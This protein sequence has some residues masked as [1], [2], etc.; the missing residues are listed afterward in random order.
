M[1]ER[2]EE[3]A[4]PRCRFA[5]GEFWSLDR[6]G[7][8][9]CEWCAVRSEL[10]VAV[11]ALGGT[12]RHGVAI[13]RRRVRLRAA[14]WWSRWRPLRRQARVGARE[15]E[16]VQGARRGWIPQRSG[17]DRLRVP[18]SRWRARRGAAEAEPVRPGFRAVGE[19]S[20]RGGT[21]PDWIVWDEAFGVAVE[22]DELVRWPWSWRLVQSARQAWTRAGWAR[23]RWGHRVRV[24]AARVRRDVPSRRRLRQGRPG[25]P[26]GPASDRARGIAANVPVGG[27]PPEWERVL[28]DVRAP[29]W[30]RLLREVPAPGKSAI[31]TLLADAAGVGAPSLRDRLARAGQPDGAG[32]ASELA[33]GHPAGEPRE[34]V[35]PD[36]GR[37]E[38]PAAGGAPRGAPAADAR[39]DGEGPADAWDPPDRPWAA[40]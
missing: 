35:G 9:P 26:V 15:A 2:F 16:P 18:G 24:A 13:A 33:T 14:R 32:P 20:H 27:F 21:R 28:R 3:R 40:S 38:H 39:G 10:G 30:A 4:C 22:P 23:S 19:R 25:A 6:G 17:L 1:D 8:G 36:P 7:P 34:P 5:P 11:R 12:F 31:L 37:V 29:D